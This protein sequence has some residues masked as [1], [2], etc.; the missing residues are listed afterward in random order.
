MRDLPSRLA[1]VKRRFDGWRRNRKVRS[2]TPEPLWALAVE[3]AG[4]YGLHRTATAL[5]VNYYSLK[6]RVKRRTT[7]AAD[8]PQ[9]DATTFIELTPPVEPRT[10]ECVVELESAAGDKMRLHVTGGATPDLV[11]LS[12][13]FYRGEP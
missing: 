6:K 4:L 11:A 13:S 12:R 9:E 7:V 2:A 1:G 8:S 3:M 5:R 10:C